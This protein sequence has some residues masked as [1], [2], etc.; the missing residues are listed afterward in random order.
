V[1][2][3]IHHI[4]IAV[5][6][7]S[8]AYRLYRDV[9]GLPL[10]KEAE[11]ADQGVRAALLAAGDSEIELLEPLGA[12]SAMARF[13]ARHGE[14]LHHICFGTPDVAA[15][16]TAAK[17]KGADLIDATPRAGLAGRIGFLHPRSCAGVL[18]E[19]ATPFEVAGGIE[20]AGSRASPAVE[21]AGSRA[22]PARSGGHATLRLKRLIIGAKEPRETAGLFQRLFAFPEIAINGG[23]RVMLAVGRGAL[24]LVP[25]GE[26]GGTEGMVA[27]SMVSDDF[28]QLTASL[29]SAG[30]RGVLRGTGEVTLEPLAT[31][32]VHLH[33]SRY[34]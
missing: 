32:G 33:I 18:V 4:G 1:I 31:H 28:D 12:N 8:E 34:D 13:I 6:S 14:G 5:Q 11:I 10:V 9:L 24:L 15:E 29:A 23:T 17:D 26:V 21:V 20:V 3:A 25:A 2:T 27:I 30:T 19:L 7:L 22:A 16:L